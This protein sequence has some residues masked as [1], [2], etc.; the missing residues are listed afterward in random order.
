MLSACP[1]IVFR[2]AQG[3]MRGQ[4]KDQATWA[5]ILLSFKTFVGFLSDGT[6][7]TGANGAIYSI[8]EEIKL[9]CHNLSSFSGN[10]R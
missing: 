10:V 3:T 6:G 7:R 4:K 1:W 9:K 5:L 2:G 8:V